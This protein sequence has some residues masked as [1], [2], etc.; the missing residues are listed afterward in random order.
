MPNCDGGPIQGLF[1]NEPKIF[2]TIGTRTCGKCDLYS[3]I[4][5]VLMLI[6][7]VSFLERRI[8]S[9]YG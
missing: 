8:E 3:V 7:E 4:K 9:R 1:L 2:Y 5:L 6:E